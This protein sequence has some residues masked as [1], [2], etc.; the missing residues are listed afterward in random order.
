M[1]LCASVCLSDN[2]VGRLRLLVLSTAVCTKSPPAGLPTSSRPA[3][4]VVLVSVLVLVVVVV[5]VVM[6]VVARHGQVELRARENRPGVGWG[7][8]TAS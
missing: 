5:L 8:K 4:A 6:V 7:E 3:P 2:P 1:R